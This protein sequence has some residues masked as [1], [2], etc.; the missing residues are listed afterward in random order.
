MHMIKQQEH[1]RCYQPK[2]FQ[3][4]IFHILEVAPKHQLEKQS[5]N[6]TEKTISP[7]LKVALVQYGQ[8]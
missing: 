4:L 5:L 2:L 3:M 1:R 8:Q 6:Q 7:P